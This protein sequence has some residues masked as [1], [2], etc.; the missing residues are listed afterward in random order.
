ML[1]GGTMSI[2]KIDNAFFERGSWYHRTKILC[3]NGTTK[4]GKLGGFNTP[5]EAEVSYKKHDEEYQKLKR[6][7]WSV[8][9]S[10][11]MMFKDY[12]IYWFENIY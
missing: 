7:Y 12:I 8:K 11:E 1:G 2:N 9:E 5:E 6:E 4:Y 10:K 3:D